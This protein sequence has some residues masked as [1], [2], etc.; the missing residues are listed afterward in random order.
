MEDEYG[1]TLQAVDYVEE[2]SERNG[3][4]IKVEDTNHP[5][6]SQNAQQQ[7]TALHPKPM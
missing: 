6:N 2:V 4:H 3:V 1:E 5:R 7:T